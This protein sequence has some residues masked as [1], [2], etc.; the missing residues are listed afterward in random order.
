M[1][2]VCANKFIC[3]HKS[4]NQRIIIPTPQIIHPN[5][6]IV[7]ITT[8]SEG[9]DG[10]NLAIRRVKFDFRYTPRIVV[11]LNGIDDDL[12]GYNLPGKLDIC[13]GSTDDSAFLILIIVLLFARNVNRTDDITIAIVDIEKLR[14]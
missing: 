8:V 9:V 3:A 14:N 12:R 7:V 5:L 6:F 1:V 2:I 10:C 13:L 11:I 4:A